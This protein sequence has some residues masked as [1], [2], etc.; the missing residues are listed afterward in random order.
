MMDQKPNDRF[1][2][3]ELSDT[4][5]EPLEESSNS[6]KN[7]LETIASPLLDTREPHLSGRNAKAPNRF[8]F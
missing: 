5:K 4:P 6:M 7:I 2:F 8:M 1:N 3:R